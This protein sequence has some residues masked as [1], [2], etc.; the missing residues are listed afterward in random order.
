MVHNPGGDDCILGEGVVPTYISQLRTPLAHQ[1]TNPTPP[2][3][4]A[5]RRC[6]AIVVS[7]WRKMV[8]IVGGRR[9]T[10]M[11]FLNP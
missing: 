5:H 4:K 8:A 9:Y 10:V 3:A 11:K 7:P 1:K 6:V 2:I